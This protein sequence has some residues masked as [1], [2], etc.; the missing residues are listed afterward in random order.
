MLNNNYTKLIN[1]R[2]NLDWAFMSNRKSH[3]LTCMCL[4]TIN[5]KKITI[6]NN[7]IK[8]ALAMIFKNSVPLLHTPLT[9]SPTGMQLCLEITVKNP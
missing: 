5:N 9:L 8:A 7:V 1:E 6:C 2:Y 4:F 3:T